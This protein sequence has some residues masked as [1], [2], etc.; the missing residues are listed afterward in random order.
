MIAVVEKAND[1]I[2]D[3]V[4]VGDFGGTLKLKYTVLFLYYILE[5]NSQKL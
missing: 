3:K 4:N 5:K 1:F 2:Y